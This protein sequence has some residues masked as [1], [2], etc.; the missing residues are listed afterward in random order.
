MSSPLT[1]NP[2]DFGC[3]PQPDFLE[4]AKSEIPE[5]KTASTEIEAAVKDFKNATADERFHLTRYDL[6][7]L[8]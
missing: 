7:P 5:L 1:F 8:C 3:Y 6:A 4:R 2:F